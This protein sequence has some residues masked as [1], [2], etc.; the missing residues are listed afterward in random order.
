MQ[1]GDSQWQRDDSHCQWRE[2][3]SRQMATLNAPFVSICAEQ[4]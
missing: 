2:T 1:W 4:I 3:T